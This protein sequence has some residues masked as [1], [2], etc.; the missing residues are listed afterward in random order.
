M[1]SAFIISAASI[2]GLHARSLSERVGN[3]TTSTVHRKFLVLDSDQQEDACYSSQQIV[4][5]VSI[6]DCFASPRMILGL[7][8][9]A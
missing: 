2:C 3:Q 9:K 8:M 6:R 5:R 4:G 7:V 1:R